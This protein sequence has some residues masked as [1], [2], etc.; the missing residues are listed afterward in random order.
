M[1]KI[2]VTY[3][4]ESKMAVL[5]T[6]DGDTWTWE[7]FFVAWE[8]QKALIEAVDRP[9]VHVIVD[10]SRSS[11]LP[12]GGSL[13]VG[14]RKMT[15]ER[16]L[17]Q[18]QTIVVG[19]HGMMATVARTASKLMGASRQELRF[20]TTMDEAVIILKYSETTPI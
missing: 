6:Y 16:H 10:V 15:H 1:E 17:R 7:D 13:L 5:C 2:T 3:F 12:N 9:K 4:D 14:L 8:Q 11:W 18:G 19:A 20:A